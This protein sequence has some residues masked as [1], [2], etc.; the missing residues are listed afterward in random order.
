MTTL[1]FST[2]L[3]NDMM[4]QLQVVGGTTAVLNIYNGALPTNCASSSAGTILASISLPAAFMA[5]ASGGSAAM[6]GSWADSSADA[7]GTAVHFRI[8][9]DA[10]A[11]TC[12]T[13]GDC[14]LSAAAMI[15]D[16]V[17]FTAGQAFSITTFT[18]TAGNA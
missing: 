4:N 10:T 8:F 18:L 12:V 7:S 14:G 6:S 11:A 16:S 3:R 15:L 1:Q 5:A 17:N 2:T 13:Q 9:T